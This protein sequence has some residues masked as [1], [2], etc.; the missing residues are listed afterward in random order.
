MDYVEAINDLINENYEIVVPAQVI[1]ELERLKISLKQILRE[2]EDLDS[3]TI[4]L[5][6]DLSEKEDILSERKRQ[7]E[8]LSKK[9]Q[10]LL[11]EK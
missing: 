10:K 1:E 7:E 4:S 9:F 5:E 6:E 2:E 8:E 3:D 11:S